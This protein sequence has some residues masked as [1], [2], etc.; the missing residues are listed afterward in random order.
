MVG[1][2]I[3]ND[4]RIRVPF[5]LPANLPHVGTVKIGLGDAKDDEAWNQS[6]QLKEHQVPC[7]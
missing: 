3:E 4:G 6:S 2:G 7:C 5:V 1:I